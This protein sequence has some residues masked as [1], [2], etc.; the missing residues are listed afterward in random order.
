MDRSSALAARR[1]ALAI[2]DA[3]G[4]A[5]DVGESLRWLCRLYWWSGDGVAAERAPGDR[6]GDPVR[7]RRGAGPSPDGQAPRYQ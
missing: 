3:A 5:V 1:E 4:R 2:H 7:V 6:P